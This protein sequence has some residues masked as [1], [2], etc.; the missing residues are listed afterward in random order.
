[1]GV[2]ILQGYLLGKPMPLEELEA[3]LR[4]RCRPGATS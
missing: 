2:D 1:M 4:A 3:I